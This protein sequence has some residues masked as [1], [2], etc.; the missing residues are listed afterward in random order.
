MEHLRTQVLFS[1]CIA[2]IEETNV[3]KTSVPKIMA[4]DGQ[5]DRLGNKGSFLEGMLIRAGPETV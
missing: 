4:C 2:N 3:L 5:R 1:N